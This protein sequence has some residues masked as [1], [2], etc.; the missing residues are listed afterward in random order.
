MPTFTPPLRPDEV[1][2]DPLDVLGQRERGHL[3]HLGFAW[4][5]AQVSEGDEVTVI[6]ARPIRRGG[7][8]L[9]V[10]A[11]G[12]LALSR[13]EHM[14][15]TT[16]LERRRRARSLAGDHVATIEGARRDPITG[17]IIGR[18]QSCAGLVFECLRR[19][20]GIEL[21]ALD[22]LP[23]SARARLVEIWGDKVVQQAEH[24]GELVGDGPW[25][26]LL[27]AHVLHALARDDP[28]GPAMQA[29]ALQWDFP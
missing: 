27:P 20:L 3:S 21:V 5:P 6:D 25:P 2:V 15:M 1:D 9:A 14:L 23:R 8:K 22:A 12:R 18:E 4:E 11:I 17:R 10:H 19:C 29:T 7:D 26:L 28:R 16:W 24:R 13:R